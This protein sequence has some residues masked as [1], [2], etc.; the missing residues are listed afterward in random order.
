MVLLL[1][2]NNPQTQTFSSLP[3]S[4]TLLLSYSYFLLNLSYLFLPYKA[5]PGVS[6]KQIASEGREELV[7]AGVSFCPW[8]PWTHSG[9]IHYVVVTGTG[10][11]PQNHPF[12]F[13]LPPGLPK[14]YCLSGES[15][16]EFRCVQPYLKSYSV[17]RFQ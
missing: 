11:F 7:S 4:P 13:P 14:P 17:I 10:W 5:T 16:S 12:W 6:V 3:P 15:L 2:S 8:S 9:N 1:P